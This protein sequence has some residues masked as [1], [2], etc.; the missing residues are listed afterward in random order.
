M[1]R[2]SP[3]RSVGDFHG[4][5]H[6]ARANGL[7]RRPTRS[8][9]IC[10]MGRSGSGLLCRGLSGT[11]LLATP[12]EYFNALTRRRFT[13]RW[14]CEPDLWSYVKAMH[15]RRTTATGLFASKLHW[16]QLVQVR[17]EAR[18]GSSDRF[19]FATDRALLDRL[20]PQALFVRIVRT[21][22]DAQAVSAWRAQQSNVWSV[23]VDAPE[24]IG[25]EPP[26]Y[27]FEG[28]EACRRTIEN[29]ELCW[30]RLIRSLDG[31]VILVTYEELSSSFAETIERVA[32]EIRPGL[33]VT[34]PEPTTR[35]L[36]DRNSR[37]LLERFRAERLAR[38]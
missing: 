9:V 37:E 10:S 6:D 15:A 11:G 12:L 5:E 25:S 17:A 36:A 27:S 1:D 33:E 14:G 26:S 3:P 7:L 30:D 21:D 16:Q 38:G 13:G 28:I 34:V 18:A 32:A 24:R 23:A 2:T 8:Y 20:F 4:A 29:G 22:L 19:V 31:E 35:R